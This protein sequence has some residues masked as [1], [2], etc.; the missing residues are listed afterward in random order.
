MKKCHSVLMVGTDLSVKGGMSTVAKNYLSNWDYAQ[1]GIKYIPT[2]IE[3]CK[4]IQILYFL[5]QYAKILSFLLSRRYEGVHLHMTHRGSTVRKGIIAYTASLLRI[6]YIVHLHL[7]YKPFYES[8]PSFARKIVRGIFKKSS[9][10]IM[11]NEDMARGI[12]EISPGCKIEVISNGVVCHDSNKYNIHARYILFLG[13]LTKRKGIYDTLE[14]ISLLDQRLPE[15]VKWMLCGSG[16]LEDISHV[17]EKY[18][19]AH[20]VAH[21]GWITDKEKEEIFRESAI[22]ILPSYREGLPMSILETM[23]FG[24][25]NISTNISGIPSIIENGYNGLLISPGDVEGLAQAILQ[26][27][28]DNDRRILMSKNAYETSKTKFS[29][30]EMIRRTYA[31][32]DE[33]MRR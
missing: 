29:L 25:P 24:I 27:L 13:V 30:S 23:A 10:N 17:I 18:G 8:L 12:K 15:D 9:C 22:S 31:V 19:I 5:I 21:L 11:L 7:E 6:K 32:Y 33:I 26:L 1:Y 3:A 4:P 16:N 2:Y 14:C 28:S 20:R